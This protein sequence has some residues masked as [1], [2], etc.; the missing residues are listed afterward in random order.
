VITL[1]LPASEM[2]NGSWQTAMIAARSSQKITFICRAVMSKWEGTSKRQSVRTVHKNEKE[3]EGKITRDE[4]EFGYRNH[5]VESDMH[6]CP[7][8]ADPE[9]GRCGTW[10]STPGSVRSWVDRLVTGLL[11]CLVFKHRG[12][13]IEE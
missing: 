7:K 11:A 13:V 12:G 4:G 1:F 2:I 9:C 3:H 6:C 10:K 5:S 8:S